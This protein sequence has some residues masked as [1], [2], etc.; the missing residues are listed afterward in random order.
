MASRSIN[1]WALATASPP[2][3]YLNDDAMGDA[4]SVVLVDGAVAGVW[5]MSPSDA[6]L[7]VRAAPFDRFSAKQ[8]AAIEEEAQVVAGL[9]DSES[10]TLIRIDNPPNLRDGKR[11][12]F[13]RP[14]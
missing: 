13:M 2:F 7:E 1:G 4:T 11:N 8:W 12:L 9:A 3:Q 5:S 6:R 14:V 10:A